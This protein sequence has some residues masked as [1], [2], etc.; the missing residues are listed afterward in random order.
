[1]CQSKVLWNKLVLHC[2]ILQGNMGGG[3][4]NMLLSL[5]LSLASLCILLALLNIINII[6]I[7]IVISII[8]TTI[9]MI[10]IIVIIIS[11]MGHRCRILDAL[12]YLLGQW[13]QHLVPTIA[14]REKD[15]CG[16]P[17]I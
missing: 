5:F 9:I 16:P 8:I 12:N 6:C 7:I 4:Q 13:L 1:M 3:V 14:R 11:W 15:P 2:F 17:S 10:I